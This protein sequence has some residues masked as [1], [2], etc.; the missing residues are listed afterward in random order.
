MSPYVR[1]SFASSSEVIEE[2]CRRLKDACRD[3]R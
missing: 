1:L 3:L 2:G